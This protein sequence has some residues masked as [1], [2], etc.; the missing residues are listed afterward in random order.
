M[1]LVISIALL[2][3]SGGVTAKEAQAVSVGGGQYMMTDQNFTIFGSADGIV[4]KLVARAHLFCQEKS[5]VEAVLL[6]ST[7]SGAV[8]GR[9]GQ[10]GQGATGTI[11][12]R[13]ASATQITA[14]TQGSSASGR[15]LQVKEYGSVTVQLAMSDEA[16]CDELAS[17][18]KGKSVSCTSTSASNGLPFR[19][20]LEDDAT[21]DVFIVEAVGAVTCESFVSG[22]SGGGDLALLR[23][24]SA[25]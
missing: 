15:F 10:F 22:F 5:S 12:F 14:A 2:V 21:K 18:S 7:G 3:V 24:C 25:K 11:Y 20:V 9:N 8:P 17:M 6:N 23:A 16:A 4:T 13:C 1:K 19:A